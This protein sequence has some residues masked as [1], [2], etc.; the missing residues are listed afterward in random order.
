M[1][2]TAPRTLFFARAG[3]VRHFYRAFADCNV[4]LNF[5]RTLLPFAI[6]QWLEKVRRCFAEWKHLG[7]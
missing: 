7:R 5:A 6:N 3:F 4:L 2:R 1:L